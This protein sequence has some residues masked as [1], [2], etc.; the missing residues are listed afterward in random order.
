MTL[1]SHIVVVVRLRVI[2]ILNHGEAAHVVD[3]GGCLGRPA[4]SLTWASTGQVPVDGQVGIVL[5]LK[6]LRV[7]VW[8][9]ACIHLAGSLLLGFEALFSAAAGGRLSALALSYDIFL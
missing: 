8:A 9:V 6:L 3:L 1:N 5:E 4:H 7:R 2:V